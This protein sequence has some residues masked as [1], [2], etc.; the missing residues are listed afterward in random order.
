MFSWIDWGC[1]VSRLDVNRV[2]DLLQDF[3]FQELFIEELGW[4]H[5]AQKRLES[6]PIG[7]ESFTYKGVAVLGGIE[8]FEVKSATGVIPDQG[9]AAC[10]LEG[11]RQNPVLSMFS[12][13]LIRSERRAFG[14]GSSAMETSAIRANTTSSRDSRGISSFRR[15][16][17][18]SVDLSELDDSGQLPLLQAAKKVQRALDIER[19]IKKFFKDY[20]D[21]QVKFTELIDGISDE[22][23]RRWYAS[24][25]LNRLMFTYFL[26]GKLFI[27]GGDE[28]YLENKLAQSKLRGPDR[29]FGEFLRALFFEAFAKPE[30]KRSPIARELTGKIKYLNGG[31]F[32]PH[33][34][35]QTVRDLDSRRSIR[36]SP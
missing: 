17:A 19:V 1:P 36:K 33:R 34:L 6:I 30:E 18:W 20:D 21:Q 26:Q 3:A 2:R 15:S 35:E 31:L 25:L 32:L 27:D 24:V 5:P 28:H 23:D 14:S 7:D 29:F 11:N 9:S 4:N 10:R 16:P 12:S 22:K 8:A 13:S